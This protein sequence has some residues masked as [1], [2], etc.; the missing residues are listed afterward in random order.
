MTRYLLGRIAGLLVTIWL[1][2]IVVFALM[3]SVPGGPFVFDKQPLPAEALENINKKYGLDG[4]VYVQYLRW[5]GAVAQGDLGVPFQSP[6]ETVVGLIQRAWPVTI[7]VGVIT[8]AVAFGLGIP[9]GVVAATRQ[10]SWLDRALTFIASLGLTIPNFVVAIWLIYAF[11]VNLKWLPTGGWGEPKHLIMPVIAYALIPMSSI[12]RYTRTS[13]LD[14][15]HADYVRL[16]RARGIPEGTIMR[17]YVLRNALAPLITVF[18]PEIPNILTG[19]IFIEATF[20]IPGLG[21]F[22]VTSLT[23]RDYPMIMALVL[24]VAFLW[25]FTYIVSDILYSVAD[26]RIRVGARRAA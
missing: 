24:L 12:A 14:V 21:R 20:V 4:P 26:P 2:T 17:R 11:A 22:F 1:I 6:T 10:N 18:G 16:A 15:M 5:L 3:K 19:S 8:L 23:N 13:V 9:L 25:G 7:L